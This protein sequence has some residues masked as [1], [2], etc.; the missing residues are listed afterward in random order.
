VERRF[1][2]LK[3]PDIGKYRQLNGAAGFLG[4]GGGLRSGHCRA[5]KVYIAVKP[6]NA[7]AIDGTACFNAQF[8]LMRRHSLK[9]ALC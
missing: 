9:G 4:C 6:A 3:R 8:A 5:A 2:H 1:V 7:Q